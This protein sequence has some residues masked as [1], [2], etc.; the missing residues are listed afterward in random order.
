[1]PKENTHIFL[2]NSV[3]DRFPSVQ[4]RDMMH[5]NYTALCFGAIVADTFFYS[6][7]SRL[8]EVA[9]RLHGKDGEKTNELTFHILEK[10]REEG[11]EGVLCMALGYISH[12]VFDMILHPII[13]Y[14]VG[15]YYDDD[16]SKRKSAVYRHR[17]IETRLDHDVNGKYHLNEILRADDMT[18]HYFLGILAD[19]YGVDRCGMVHALKKQLRAN[20]CFRSTMVYWG[21]LILD[22]L[23]IGDFGLILPL[24]YRHL[25]QEHPKLDQ[26]I[27]FRDIIEGDSRERKLQELFDHAMEESIRRISAAISF[28][29]GTIDKSAAMEIIRGESL[30][31]GREGCPVT[32]IIHTA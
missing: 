28:Y 16:H 5:A 27:R 7:D 12:C 10:A 9:E 26:N 29:Q 25:K 15:N 18:L 2:I 23:G 14:L 21:I 32:M 1:L 8:I 11:S 4:A 30:D 20:R 19:R 22:K 6:P 31:T 3:M 24:F 13:Y 17:L